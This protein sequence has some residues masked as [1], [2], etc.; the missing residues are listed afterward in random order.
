MPAFA[1]VNVKLVS[2]QA[3]MTDTGFQ[4]LGEYSN[5]NKR[6]YR[7]IPAGFN[8]VAFYNRDKQ[9]LR[10]MRFLNDGGFT[11]IA[12]HKNIG[13]FDEVI[14]GQFASGS[15]GSIYSRDDLLFFNRETGRIVVYDLDY[16]G[17]MTKLVDQNISP[18]SKGGTWDIVASGYL[19][20]SHGRHD[21]L[22]YNK[23]EGKARFY[24]LQG[25][26]PSY[27]FSLV[28]SYKGWRKNWDQIIPANVDGDSYSDF[29][30][31]NQD[32]GGGTAPATVSH[33]HAKFISFGPNF[34][35]TTI[36]QTATEWPM[37]P[38]VV[39]VPGQFR[40][41]NR[42]DFVVYNARTGHGFIWYNDGSGQYQ[43]GGYKS[44]QKRWTSIVP[45][46]LENGAGTDLLFFT[47]QKKLNVVPVYM[48][49]ASISTTDFQEWL[50]YANEAF[51]PAGIFFTLKDRGWLWDYPQIDVKG[52]KVSACFGKA[53][54]DVL[55]DTADHF[56]LLGEPN[57]IIVFVKSSSGSGTGCS[58]TKARYIVMPEYTNT[59]T[60][61][62]FRDGSVTDEVATGL[63][64]PKLFVH[65]AGHHFSLA[66]TNP[67]NL[68]LPLSNPYDYDT[69]NVLG[70]GWANVW[71]TPPNPSIKSLE[72]KLLD[73]WCDDSGDNDLD[74]YDSSPYT[75]NPERHNIMSRGINCDLMYRLN[76]G[77]VRAVRENLWDE[78]SYYLQ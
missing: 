56:R 65:E 3:G 15:V 52:K 29:L 71:D 70:D 32:G 50:R 42:T 54:K 55:N 33:G 10:I 17:S 62:R 48:N 36:S 12:T 49:G 51:S 28:E 78:R 37:A 67:D 68:K 53:S 74:I 4:K 77:Q 57:D 41:D 34:D 72:W 25:T 73:N 61:L 76:P 16:D 59:S 6:Y 58:S 5:W 23:T 21:M 63:Y 64:N 27:S 31:Y 38:H 2:T 11:T 69:D 45:L 24:R 75:L 7:V 66:H 60:T 40:G 30:F 39:V 8:Q 22:V 9:Y 46:H 18:T 35:L 14:S 44:W 13:Q 26:Y 20:N 1:D 47:T 19:G 43:Y